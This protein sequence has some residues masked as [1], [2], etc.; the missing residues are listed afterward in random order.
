MLN[1]QCIQ[2]IQNVQNVQNIQNVLGIQNILNKQK[3]NHLKP[4][5]A[6]LKN[7]IQIS[8]TPFRHYSPHSVL[9]IKKSVGEKNVCFTE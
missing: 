4:S 1:L 2:I 8:N 9:L 3:V 7:T 6:G 5:P